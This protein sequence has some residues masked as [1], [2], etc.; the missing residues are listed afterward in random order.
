MRAMILAAGRGERMGTLTQHLPKPLLKIKNNYLIEYAI[1]ALVKANITEIVINI[2]YYADK[3]KTAIGDGHQYGANILYSEEE[4]RLETG[5][6]IVKALP[7]LGNDPFLVM[8]S[9]IITQFPFEKLKQ[10]PIQLAHLVLVPNPSF[11]ST[12]DFSLSQHQVMMD[13]QAV[14]TYA[15]IGVF[16]PA[17]FSQQSVRHFP[18]R[19]VLFPAI[20]AKKITGEVYAGKWFN[21]GTPQQLQE[22]VLNCDSLTLK[23]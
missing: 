7:L 3:I 8:S 16:N 15:N 5:G 23:K 20:R 4:H 14:Y 21:I 11:K 10:T 1:N 19:D 17:L 12:G 13:D 22:A 2:S 9:D 6:G 18:L